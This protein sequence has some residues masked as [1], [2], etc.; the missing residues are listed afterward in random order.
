[1]SVFIAKRV[2]LKEHPF[3]ILAWKVEFRNLKF[4][5]IFTKFHIK[6]L[7][8]TIIRSY[9]LWIFYCLKYKLLIYFSLFKFYKRMLSKFYQHKLKLLFVWLTQNT[10]CYYCFR[11]QYTRCSCSIYTKLISIIQK[12]INCKNFNN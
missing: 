3:C 4:H 12:N 7:S 9:Q 6:F 11:S 2:F 5:I 8:K 1:M 10:I